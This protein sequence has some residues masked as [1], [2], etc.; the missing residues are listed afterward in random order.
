MVQGPNI[1]QVELVI[2]RDAARMGN[3]EAL[4]MPGE[5]GLVEGTVQ[6]SGGGNK[7][8]VSIRQL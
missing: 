7:G 6:Y 4:Q 8:G 2:H 1:A 5:K 3:S